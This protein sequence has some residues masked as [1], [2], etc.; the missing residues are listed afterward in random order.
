MFAPTVTGSPIRN[1]ARVIARH[2]T[3]GR[4]YYSGVLALLGHDEHGGQTLDAPI[5]IRTAHLDAAGGIRVP[6]GATLVRSSVPAD[7]V[8]ETHAK[9][10]GVLRALAGLP[11]PAGGIEPYTPVRLADYHG[12]PEALAQRNRGLARFWLDAQVDQPLLRLAGRTALVV[13]AEDAW[14]AML[15]HQLRRLGVTTTVRAWDEDLQAS[16]YDLLVAGPGPGDPRETGNPRIASVRA[17]IA[18]R[19][20]AGS[21]LLAVCLSHQVLAGLLGL[22]VV[23]LPVPSQGTQRRVDVFGTSARVG[24]YNTFTATTTRSAGLPEGVHAAADAT[25]GHVDALR[26]PSFASVQFHLESLLSADG[27]D[28][29]ADLVMD[30]LADRTA[31]EDGDA[32]TATEAH[33]LATCRNLITVHRDP[34]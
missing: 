26:G 30:I 2:E 4:G 5:L 24:F 3:G 8:A 29:L 13:D 32:D 20:A 22:P 6:V 28:V 27:L 25:T 15:A 1:A 16:R 10:A 9:A 12:V 33:G 14:T 19:L 23:A 34:S 31:F 11:G 17:L 7:E 21:P 18:D